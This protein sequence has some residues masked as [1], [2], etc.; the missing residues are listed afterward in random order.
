MSSANSDITLT[1][2]ERAPFSYTQSEGFS[3]D[4]TGW[5]FM[6]EVVKEK[7]CGDSENDPTVV[8]SLT[9]QSR[10]SFTGGDPTTLSWVWTPSEQ[11]DVD[12][13]TYLWRI[14]RSDANHEAVLGY[15]TLFLK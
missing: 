6:F 13:G 4:M 14:W 9:D 11:E 10:F 7:Q 15:G 8:F 1:K 12:V 5:E 3:D 2:G